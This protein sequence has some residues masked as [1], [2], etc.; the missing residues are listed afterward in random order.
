VHTGSTGNRQGV[1]ELEKLDLD[2]LP[3]IVIIV[4]EMADLMMSPAG[5][6]RRGAAP[7][8][9]GARGGLHVILAPSG[10]SVDVITGTSRRIF[11]PHL[12]SG[13]LEVDSRTS[14]AKW[15]RAAARRATCSYGG[16]RT[17]RRVHGPF[18]SDEEV[19]KVVRHLSHKAPGNISR[20]SP[21]RNQPMKMA[22]RGVRFHRHGHR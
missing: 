20:R 3:F 21:P 7:G 14:W 19:E 10:R 13:H 2:P 12:V 8:A 11:Q 6:R 4:D 22:P 18:V 15:R 9:N 17:H 16:R 1:Y 5:Y